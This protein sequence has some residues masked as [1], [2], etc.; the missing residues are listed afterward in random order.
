M[1]PKPFAWLHA[2]RMAAMS[3]DGKRTL[4]NCHISIRTVVISA[5][6]N[7]LPSRYSAFDSVVDDDAYNVMY[8]AAWIAYVDASANRRE[9]QRIS[10]CRMKLPLGNKP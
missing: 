10:K 2:A 9:M 3:S 4:A 7:A 8:Q 6:L 5:A 1:K